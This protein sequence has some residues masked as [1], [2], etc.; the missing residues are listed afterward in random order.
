MG[1][2]RTNEAMIEIRWSKETNEIDLEGTPEDLQ[3]VRQ[4]ILHLLQTDEA[5][6][7]IPA[8]I[9]F[10][11]APYSGRLSSLVIQ[12]SEGSTRVSVVVD[13]LEVQGNSKHLESFADWFNFEANQSHYHCHF[14]YYPDNE[15]IHPDSLPLVISVRS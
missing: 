5:Q 2:V 3:Y 10:D 15:W 13:C 12:N 4:S 14:E 6:A 9:D 8:A 11:S 7:V 1:N